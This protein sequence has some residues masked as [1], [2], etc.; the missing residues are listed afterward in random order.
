M[1]YILYLIILYYCIYLII[2]SY[3]IISLGLI[4][5]DKYFKYLD[6]KYFKK[7]SRTRFIYLLY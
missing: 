4:H 2:V 3:Y 7:I 1:L 6:K 5:L